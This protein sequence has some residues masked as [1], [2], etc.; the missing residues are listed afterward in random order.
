VPPIHDLIREVDRRW[1]SSADRKINLRIIGASALMLQAS[2]ERGT[3]DGDILETADLDVETKTR[4]L[5]LAGPGTDLSKRHGLYIEFVAS[6]LPLL[7]Q[8]PMWLELAE[9]NGEL[10][11]F[12]IEV[13]TVVDVVVSKIKRLHGNDLRDIEAMIDLEL[14][15]HAVL[16]DRFRSAVDWF[17][18]DARAEDLPKYI[19][20]LHRVERDLFGTPE[21]EIDLPDSLWDP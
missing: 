8:V 1:S 9:L 12:R 20:N 2:Y 13:L 18:L 17:L 6:G 14:V 3:K 16:I 7:P 15:P 5:E 21:T 11:H 4:L 19:E 10:A